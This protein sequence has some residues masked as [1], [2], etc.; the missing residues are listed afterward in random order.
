MN[1]DLGVLSWKSNLTYNNGTLHVKRIESIILR[2]VDKKDCRVR[3][4]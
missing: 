2:K 1:G 4:I 3:A